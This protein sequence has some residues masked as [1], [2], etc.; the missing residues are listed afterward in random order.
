[1]RRATKFHS[2]ILVLIKLPWSSLA[3]AIIYKLRVTSRFCFVV[4]ELLFFLAFDTTKSIL[5]PV[6]SCFHWFLSTKTAALE[7]DTQRTWGLSAETHHQ[8]WSP[9]DAWWSLQ[10]GLTLVSLLSF[11]ALVASRPLRANTPEKEFKFKK[12]TTNKPCVPKLELRKSCEH[13]RTYPACSGS[14]CVC[15]RGNQRGEV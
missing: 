15:N 11:D 4:A 5:S 12:K 10:P 2:L 6:S 8:S 14:E 3:A 1:M 7:G 13:H 9:G